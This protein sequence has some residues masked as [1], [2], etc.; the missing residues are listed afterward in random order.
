MRT[1]EA[2][3]GSIQFFL[4]RTLAIALIAVALA[5]GQTT[6]GLGSAKLPHRTLQV[7]VPQSTAGQGD[8]FNH[9][10]YVLIGA[11]SS[12]PM[13]NAAPDLLQF[14]T[15]ASM[16]CVYA[17]GPVYAGCNPASGGNRHP[18]GGWGAIALVDAYDNPDAG[19]DLAYFSR[20]F[21]L[22]PAN[23][24]KVYAVGNRS[25]DIPPPNNTWAVEEALD[26]EWAH[27]MAPAAK[28]YLVEACSSADADL[29]YA[30]Q[31]AT[32]LVSAAGGGDISNSWGRSEFP[33]EATWDR[34]FYMGWSPITY[35]A[36]SGDQGAAVIYPS[37]SPFVV[38][39]GGT[40]IDRDASG[41]LL[42]ESCWPSTG[43][44]PS[45]YESAQPSQTALTTGPR[46]T[47]DLSSNAMGVN[48]YDL[49]NGGWYVVAGTSVSSPTLAGIV[50]SARSRLG[51]GTPGTIP[52]NQEDAL[53]YSQLG[54]PAFSKHFYD[55]TT[56]SNGYSAG[57]GYDWCTGLGSP[58]GK[59]GK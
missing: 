7:F 30:E 25:C 43:G 12:K 6:S 57:A 48:V 34:Y 17:V 13:P 46:W 4:V 58:R 32:D 29:F 54:T 22:P 38:S 35:F 21:D 59:R 27:A 28:I 52:V 5:A 11:T 51:E 2:H 56:G 3:I 36:A 18:T 26:I 53:I 9:T 10:N 14:E 44:G 47:P 8:G 39:A 55:V 24:T 15:P 23:F 20:Y 1:E 19:Y 41:N 16:G 31:V 40:V 33:E 49:F 50:N 42:G 37:A 45:L